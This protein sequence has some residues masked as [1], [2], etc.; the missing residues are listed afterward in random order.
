MFV[1]IEMI[2]LKG[3]YFAKQSPYKKNQSIV[4]W[5]SRYPFYPSHQVILRNHLTLLYA[6][7]HLNASNLQPPLKPRTNHPPYQD[8][9][10]GDSKSDT[11]PPKSEGTRWMD[12]LIEKR[13]R[14]KAQAKVQASEV[15]ASKRGLKGPLRWGSA[16]LAW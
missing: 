9:N 3:L 7:A 12:A 2:D 15:E 6:T 10:G 1:R 14:N 4:H 16:A 5:N 11:V 8:C 13:A